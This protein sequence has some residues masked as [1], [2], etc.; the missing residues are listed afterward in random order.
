MEGMNPRGFFFINASFIYHP[1][2]LLVQPYIICFDYEYLVQCSVITTHHSCTSIFPICKLH[3]IT[4]PQN[5]DALKKNVILVNDNLQDTNKLYKQTF[6]FIPFVQ[7]ISWSVFVCFFFFF[8]W[9]KIAKRQHG[10][11]KR[12][13]CDLVN[14]MHVGIGKKNNDQV[15][16]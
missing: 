16:S 2:F 13:I 6:M 12:N 5:L 9:W 7:H 14:N 1:P 10:F 4:F 15:P 11:L 8:F 3:F